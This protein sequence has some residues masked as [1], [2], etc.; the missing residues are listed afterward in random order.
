M[1]ETKQILVVRRDLKMR[2][3]KEI[4][5]CAHASMAVFT[6]LIK[7]E[8]F[9]KQPLSDD[10]FDWRTTPSNMLFVFKYIDVLWQW[11]SSSFAKICVTVNSEQELLDVYNKAKEAGMLCSLITDSGRTEFNGVP[12]ITC[13]AIGPDYIEKIDPIT[14]HLPLY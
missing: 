14:K 1:S 7:V 11:F 8:E 4:A 5:Q 2:R 13:C 3:G 6:R 9:G 10:P 12:T